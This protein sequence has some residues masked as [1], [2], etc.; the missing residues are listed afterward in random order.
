MGQCLG[1]WS[2]IK[3]PLELGHHG[4]PLVRRSGP[5]FICSGKV[6]RIPLRHL[7]HNVL[8]AFLTDLFKRA[9]SER[10]ITWTTKISTGKRFHEGSVFQGRSKQSNSCVVR[11]FIDVLALVALPDTSRL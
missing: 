9:G 10:G 6:D 7:I 2:L 5:H 3:F 4:L 11:S 8:V 1:V